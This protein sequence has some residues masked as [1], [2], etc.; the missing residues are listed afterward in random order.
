MAIVEFMFV[1][2]L[3]GMAGL[4]IIRAINGERKQQQLQ[5]AFYQLLKEQNG[6]ISPIQMAAGARVDPQLAKQY[7][8]AQVKT[9]EALPE[10]DADGDTF[11][12]FP[13]L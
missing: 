4:L 9:F 6:L 1:L 7:L 10:V 3:A 12:R 11:Y 2:A 5:N 8:E 13:K